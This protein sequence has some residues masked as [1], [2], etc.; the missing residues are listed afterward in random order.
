MC[1][2]IVAGTASHDAPERRAIRSKA[3]SQSSVHSR[4]HGAA[5]AAAAGAHKRER[6]RRVVRIATAAELDRPGRP[7]RAHIQCPPWGSGR[8]R[9]KLTSATRSAANSL[10]TCIRARR[11]MLCHRRCTPRRPEL[12]PS[13]QGLQP[14]G[15]LR[16]HA[17]RGWEHEHHCQGTPTCSKHAA[18][19]SDDMAEVRASGARAPTGSS[20]P[21]PSARGG[22]RSA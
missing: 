12:Q 7:A 17:R 20:P 16:G 22:Q 3:G 2:G 10:R 19:Y 13:V 4:T 15:G 5:H 18:P 21:G 8:C 1:S 14:T 6:D 11:L 9:C